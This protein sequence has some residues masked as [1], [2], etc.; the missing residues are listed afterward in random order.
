[1]AF[2][3]KRIFKKRYFVVKFVIN[4][5]KLGSFNSNSVKPFKKTL[6]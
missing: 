2:L 6:V 1:M 5:N 4:D 3:R